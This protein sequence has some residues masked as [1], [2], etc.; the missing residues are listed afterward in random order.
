MIQSVDKLDYMERLFAA[1]HAKRTELYV[2]TG[3]WHRLNR[4]DVKFVIQQRVDLPSGNYALADLYL[5]QLNL[6]I[7]INELPHKAKRQLMI[8]EIWIYK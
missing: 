6:W 8:S 4:T 2:I 3:I 1:L 7:E 5:P